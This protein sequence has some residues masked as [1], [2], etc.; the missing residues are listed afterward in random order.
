MPSI[1]IMWAA[2]IIAALAVWGPTQAAVSDLFGPISGGP[3]NGM[4]RSECYA[5]VIVP[6]INIQESS[7]WSDSNRTRND[8]YGMYYVMRCNLF[9]EYA[10]P[11][12]LQPE[13][14]H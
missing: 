9:D 12:V 2:S 11:S 10:D 14:E 8:R 7:S 3:C 5:D 13:P 1:K 4:S 6:C